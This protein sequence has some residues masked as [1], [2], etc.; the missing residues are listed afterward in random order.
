MAAHTGLACKSSRQTRGPNME[1]GNQIRIPRLIKKIM[2]HWYLMAKEKKAVCAG[3][4]SLVMETTLQGRPHARWW[5]AA[6]SKLNSIFVD[7]FCLTLLCSGIFLLTYW[8]LACVFW[9]PFLCF[10]VLRVCVVFL[11]FLILSLLTLFVF[12]EKE[13]GMELDGEVGK[14]WEKLGEG[15]AQSEYVV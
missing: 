7:C 6:Q 15:K 2:C 3:G 13:R 10:F 12:K 11:V 8:P 5:T 14:I 1:R 9:F 4:V